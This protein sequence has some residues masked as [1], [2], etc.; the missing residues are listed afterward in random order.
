MRWVLVLIVASLSWLVVGC[1]A[2][3]TSLRP[4][5]AMGEK[6]ASEPRLE[7]EWTAFSLDAMGP[8]EQ[9]QWKINQRPDGCYAAE[10]VKSGP[11]KKDGN[12]EKEVYRSCLVILKEKMFFDT[13]LD[14][15]KIGSQT[16]E[17]KDMAPGMVTVHLLGRIA[18]QPDFIRLTRLTGSWAKQNVPEDLRVDRGGG[19][20]V[21][22][23]S[24]QQLRTLLEDHADEKGAMG[25]PWYLCRRGVDCGARVVDA[26]L[27]YSPDDTNVLQGAGWFFIRLQQYDK[28]LAVFRHSA[29][30][31]PED[32]SARE[33]VG[34]VSLFHKEY[35]E[36]RKEFA[37]A[38]KLDPSDSTPELLTGVSYFFEGNYLEAH[39]VFNKLLASPSSDTMQLI[40]FDYASVARLGHR[41]QAEALLSDEMARFVGQKKEQTLLLGATGRITDFSPEF[42]DDELAEGYGVYYA[43]VRLVKGDS[44]R[45]RAALEETIKKT[46]SV[47]PGHL[48][49][50]IELD[51]LNSSDARR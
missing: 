28:A 5:Y 41:Q 34:F 2:P 9:G 43:L 12:D 50:A 23:G 24:T 26:E 11:D 22:T 40:V 37:A 16:V 39:K 6:P 13:E 1:V 46:D 44:A 47:M 19:S 30:L 42:T 29:E 4:L 15:K 14:Q 10:S 25:S 48:L 3:A 31:Q 8:S 32:T 51:R 27:T 38:A 49:A 17:P 18:A 36:A 7:G 21:L 33:Q 20:V 35:P 45:A